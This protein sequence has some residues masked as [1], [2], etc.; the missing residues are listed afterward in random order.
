MADAIRLGELVAAID[1]HSGDRHSYL[2]LSDYELLHSGQPLPSVPENVI[3]IPRKDEMNEAEI[4]QN[5]CLSLKD[6]E[7]SAEF[8]ELLTLEKAAE[9]FQERIHRYSLD[10][11]WHEFREQMLHIQ[12]A[13][14]C[15][16]KG[17]SFLE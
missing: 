2:R 10:D 13:G 5:F 6:E 17:I 16:E 9:E 4:R 12:V 14:W 7:L 1:K 8:T 3:P 11:A 15:E